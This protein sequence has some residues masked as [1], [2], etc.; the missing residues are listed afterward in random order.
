MT[1][2]DH[3]LSISLVDLPRHIGSMTHKDLVWAAPDDLGTSSMAVESGTSIEL[4]VD[5]TS[6]DSGVLV[7]A[8]TAVDLRGECV[9]CLID[10]TAHH[11]VD[12]SEVYFEAPDPRHKAGRTG[13]ADSDEGEDDM[14]FI[15]AHDTIDLEPLLRDS[16]VTLVDDRPLCRPDCPGLCPTCGERLSDLP[17]DHHH[18]VMDPRFAGLAGLLGQ[19]QGEEI[20]ADEDAPASG[21]IPHPERREDR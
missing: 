1:T 20:D 17:A 19:L 21:T 15:G 12:A 13:E 18:D 6:V 7:S 14:L 16:I 3:A 5:L 4:S 8:R 10:V 11:D 9:R 2:T